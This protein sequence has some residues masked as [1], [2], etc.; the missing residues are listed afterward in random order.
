MLF[1]VLKIFQNVPPGQFKA[2]L[3]RLGSSKISNFR[4]R[5]LFRMTYFASI[6]LGRFQLR[7]DIDKFHYFRRIFNLFMRATFAQTF[8]QNFSQIFAQTFAT[9]FSK[10][11]QLSQQ[12][13]EWQN[14]IEKLRPWTPMYLVPY[15]RSPEE[16]SFSLGS[17]FMPD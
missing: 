17:R 12:N 3:P 9:T 8:A 4:L 16:S 1:N 5:T 11:Q 14:P 10:Y 13:W 6:C 2:V 15:E 7:F